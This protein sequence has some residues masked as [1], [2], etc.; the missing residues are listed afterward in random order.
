MKPSLGRVPR[1]RAHAAGL[2]RT[3]RPRAPWP[4]ASPTWSRALDVVVGPDPT[5]LRSLPRPEASWP[6]VLE[7]PRVPARVAWSPTLGYADGRRRG[8]GLVRAGRRRCS[9]RWAPRSVEVDT[10]FERDPVGDWLTMVGACARRE[11]RPPTPATGAGTR[12]TPCCALHAS[13]PPRPRP[14]ATWCEIFDECPPPEPGARGALPRRPAPRHPDHRGRARRRSALGGSGSVNGP[15]D[16][17]WVKFTYPFNMTRS[18]AAT[19]CA[20]LTAAGLPVGPAAGR[21]P[22]RRSG[23]AALGRRPRGGARPR[24]HG[25]TSAPS[26][27][28]PGRSGADWDRRRTMS[29]GTA[30]EGNQWQSAPSSRSSATSAKT[31]P[32]GS[33]PATAWTSR[34]CASTRC[35]APGSSATASGPGPASRS[36][37]TPARWT[38]S[39]LA[40]RWHYLEYDFYSTAGSYIYEPANSVHTLDVPED[41]TEDTDVLFVIEGALLNLDPDGRVEYATPTGPAIARGLLRPARGRRASPAPTAS[42]S[43]PAADAERP[44]RC[45]S[46]GRELAA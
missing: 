5:D 45:P 31:T 4:G 19:V 6:A 1:R 25:R 2:A 44:G 9:S 18:P 21:P 7:D 30:T 24:P 41:N 23:G 39:P 32:R 26:L 46:S 27:S 17:N 40:G 22:A 34:W 14:P 13:R 38:A 8:A 29:P 12:S 36:T 15:G 20:G 11:P 37:A 10:V 42:S 28:G 16:A 35:T 43:E 3:C 33:T